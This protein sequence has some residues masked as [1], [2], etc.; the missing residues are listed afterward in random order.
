MKVDFEK[1]LQE[2]AVESGFFDGVLD[3]DYEERFDAWLE[4][5]D[6]NDMIDYAQRWGKT[7]VGE[8]K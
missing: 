6:V 3:D 2:I 4:T 1:Y 7:L 8:N 5:K